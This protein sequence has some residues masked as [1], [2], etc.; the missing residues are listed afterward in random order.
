MVFQPSYILSEKNKQLS[1]SI[2]AL[3]GFSFFIWLI[4][5]TVPLKGETMILSS[6]EENHF[7]APARLK[8][9]II[10]VD[11]PVD[12][13]TITVLDE[14][15]VPK[16]PAHVAWYMRGPKPGE[17]GNSVIDGHSGW[18]NNMPA[19]FDDLYKLKKG[20]KI[21]VED[22]KGTVTIFVVREL[23]TY[24]PKADAKEVFNPSDQVAHLNLITCSGIWDELEK[25]HSKRLVVFSD[26]E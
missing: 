9:P 25:T 14:M 2:V 10:N 24:D 15:D 11:A 22:E 13:V 4:L 16:N 8:I 3:L 23:R 21:Y 5:Q 19:V 18:R 1:R 17:A 6:E 26:K 20:D 12:H 7:I